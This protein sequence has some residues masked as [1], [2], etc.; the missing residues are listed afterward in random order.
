VREENLETIIRHSMRN[1]F[2]D[3]S[4]VLMH[5]HTKLKSEVEKKARRF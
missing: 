4:L 3:S 1:F 2:Y 5:A